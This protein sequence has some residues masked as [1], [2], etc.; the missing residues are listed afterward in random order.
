MSV[1]LKISSKAVKPE[2]QVEQSVVFWLLNNCFSVD[3]YDSKAVYS[4]RAKSYRKN[5]GIVEGHS[6]IAGSDPCGIAIYLELKSAGKEK[7]IRQD[8][9]LFLLRKIEANCFALVTSSVEHLSEIYHKWS[10][11]DPIDKKEYLRS[12]LPKRFLSKEGRVLSPA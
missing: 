12:Q 5:L 9:Y 1:S 8:Q 6:D 11:M 4:V 7:V 2:K 3:I 10:L